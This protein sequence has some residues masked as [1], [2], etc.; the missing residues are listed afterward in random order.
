MSTYKNTKN[1]KYEFANHVSDNGDSISAAPIKELP[2]GQ[3]YIS[4]EA[5]DEI[6]E[7]ELDRR[8]GPC[9]KNRADYDNE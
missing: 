6:V 1:K 3:T 7:K 9:K 8:F 2:G 5:L 4:L